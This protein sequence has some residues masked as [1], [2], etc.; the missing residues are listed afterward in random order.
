MC[1]CACRK[2]TRC[3]TDNISKDR[4]ETGQSP[5][6]FNSS[7]FVPSRMETQ[8]VGYSFQ[9][10]VHKFFSFLEKRGVNKGETIVSETLLSPRTGK[11]RDD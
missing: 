5:V 9:T 3:K 1:V 7:F 11:T 8:Y 2:K 4:R 6:T 10:W